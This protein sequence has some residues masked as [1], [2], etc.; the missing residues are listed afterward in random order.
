MR[1]GGVPASPVLS[2]TLPVPWC[3]M[4]PSQRRMC[5]WLCGGVV[6]QS[7]SQSVKQSA[8]HQGP[9]TAPLGTF[10]RVLAQRGAGGWGGGGIGEGGLR[11]GGAGGRRFGLSRPR[12][13]VLS[14]H[15]TRCRH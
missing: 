8:K 7:V 14:A 3:S 9:L 4:P 2:R 5:A 1:G 6:S 13:G 10:A 11:W 15:S 12:V